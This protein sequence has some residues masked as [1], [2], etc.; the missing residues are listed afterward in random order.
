MCGIHLIWG[1]EAN[2]EAMESMLQNSKHR[3]PDQ[4]ESLSP[5][6][7]LWIGVN[8]LKILHTGSEAD[9]PFWSPDSRSL[10][11]WNGEL[12]NFQEH[13]NLLVQMGIT[14]STHSDTE[15]V[16]HMIR[17]FG[18]KALEKLQG[19]F[20]FIYVDL[21]EKSVLIARD[22]NGE[23]PL[24]YAQNPDTLM[25]SSESRSIH[26]LKSSPLD[27]R[28]FESYFYL[29]APVLGNS[30]YKGIHEWKPQRYS[31]LSNHSA[32]RWDNISSASKHNTGVTYPNFKE[33]LTDS[34]L[35]QFH[36][37]VPVGMLLS[38]GSDSSLI[39]A[40]WQ[41][42]TGSHLPSYTIQVESK[43]RKKYADGD[44]A[45]R[46]T[47]QY[48]SSHHL[49]EI[50]QRTFWENWEDYLKSVDQPIG[51]SAGFLY[52][53]IGKEA[54]NTVKVLV[55]GAGADELWGG[56]QRHQA[57]A[58]YQNYK[59]PLL[60]F[61]GILG[62]L[63]LGRSYQKF[64]SA[65]ETDPRKTFLN[66]SGLRDIP[67]D[68][69]QDYERIF[70][71]NL[72][73]YKQMLDF[74]RQVYLV[75]DVLKIQDNALMA[76]SLEGRSPYLDASMLALW[77]QVQDESLLRGKLWIKK[78]LEELDLTWVAQRKKL[79]FGLPLQEW[80]AENGEFA[81]RI[82]SS[83]KNFEKTHGEHFPPEMRTLCSRPDLGTKHH[84]LTLYN[85]F[86]LAEW[87]KLQKL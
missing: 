84:F 38:G 70:N 8:R 12:Y 11:L 51:D 73:E 64:F 47:K 39:Y 1:K 3:G 37:D 33:T 23:K 52:W 10:L 20:A 54:K 9:Q 60:R 66:F 18:T 76:H 45:S 29:R 5:W 48:L 24:F 26:N 32:F 69:A 83:L 7:G 35:N 30:F 40:I 68:L 46:F 44:S 31:K 82:F 42:E 61:R 56:Y 36:A 86:L 71:A 28:Q 57:F 6:P 43:Y 65:I 17:V 78:Y 72:H 74:D 77:E 58:L 16:L 49:V 2:R 4:Q 59:N 80:F 87:V 21:T 15:V 55:S 63:P 25:V 85:L 53:M 34:I 50:D 62:K 13:R 41:R 67:A 22:R 14:L 79:G 75:Q 27:T 81:K 19:M